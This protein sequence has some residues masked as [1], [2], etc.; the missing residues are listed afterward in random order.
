M[1]QP[2]TIFVIATT[3]QVLCAAASLVESIRWWKR[4]GRTDVVPLHW[5]LDDWGTWVPARIALAIYPLVLI[6][7]AVPGSLL[8]NVLD[9]ARRQGLPP[10][11]WVHGVN[12]TATAEEIVSG[13]FAF[14]SM[15][16]LTVQWA[17]CRV[18]WKER[19]SNVG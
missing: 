17:A 11:S 19:D 14:A 4:F 5:G 8:G 9:Q 10:P 2:G 6:A 15:V 12:S 13:T 16:I 3:V 1:G 7:F 18:G